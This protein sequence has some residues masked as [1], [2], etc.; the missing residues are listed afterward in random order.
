MTYSSDKLREMIPCY[1]NHTLSE[2]ERRAFEES[3][4]QHPG[5]KS[6]VEEFSKIRQYYE[7]IEREIPPPSDVLF[8]RVLEKIQ[9]QVRLSFV[10][11]KKGYR[12][13]VGKCLKWVFGSPRVSWGIVAVQF[14]TILLLLIVLPKGGG[15]KTLTSKQALPGEGI[16]INVVFDKESREREIREV[17]NRVG[18]KIVMGPSLDGLYILQVEKNQDVG[19]VISNLK[20][21]PI[22]T[23][24]EKAY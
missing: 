23:F 11:Q 20:K 5:L 13:W 18:A 3:L 9:P 6:E 22:V 16:K 8:Q 4:D 10:P 15:F 21:S 1:L 24:A 14:A 2:K 17:L 12:E 7:E 19:Q